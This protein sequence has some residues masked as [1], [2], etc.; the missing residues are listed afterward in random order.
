MGRRWAV[1]EVD[2][3]DFYPAALKCSVE[4]IQEISLADIKMFVLTVEEEFPTRKRRAPFLMVRLSR[5]V[6]RIL[7]KDKVTQCTNM[8]VPKGEVPLSTGVRKSIP[9]EPELLIESGEGQ[10]VVPLQNKMSLNSQEMVAFHRF[11]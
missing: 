6:T 7:R 5:L 10:P 2:V 8:C 11:S 9:M 4:V 1:R 3:V